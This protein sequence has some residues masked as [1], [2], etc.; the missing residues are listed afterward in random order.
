MKTFTKS[1]EGVAGKFILF[2]LGMFLSVQAVA[3]EIE[4]DINQKNDHWYTAW[5]V[6]VGLALFVI[7]LVSIVGASKTNR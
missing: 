5:W 1:M 7:V 2:F 4:I 3:Q 6:W